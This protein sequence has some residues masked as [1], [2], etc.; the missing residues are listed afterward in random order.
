[1]TYTPLILGLLGIVG[2]LF[3]NL[4]QLAKINKATNGN[5]NLP[6]YW[7]LEKYTIMIAILMVGV[8]IVILNELSQIEYFANWKGLGFIA[9]GYMG[10]SLLVFAMGKASQ[11]IGKVD[12][13]NDK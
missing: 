10:Q 5:A 2:I 6:K 9:I 4:I 12:E 11:K 1:M 13:P 7:K 8:A 3:H